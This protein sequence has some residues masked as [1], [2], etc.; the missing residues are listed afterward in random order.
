MD[1][2]EYLKK[3]KRLNDKLKAQTLKIEQEYIRS[4]KAY[5]IGDILKDKDGRILKVDAINSR[6]SYYQGM[7]EVT[8][9]GVELDNL[10]LEPCLE[11]RDDS[12]LQGDVVQKLKKSK[13]SY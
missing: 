12:M 1:K 8:Y 2:E 3:I 7:P 6:W 13:L 10:D 9:Y 11:Q 4:F 5:K